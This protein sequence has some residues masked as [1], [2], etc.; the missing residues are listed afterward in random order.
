MSGSVPTNWKVEFNPKSI[1]SV[2]PNEKKEVQVPVTPSDK[3]IAGDYVASFR[4]NAKRRVV[5]RRLPHHR[6][7]LDAVGHRR[8]RH[9]RRGAAGA[10]GRGR[11]LRPPVEAGWRR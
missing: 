9:H 5:E 7:D 3:T 1:P 10:A 2:A 4:A 8:H 6:H 11:A